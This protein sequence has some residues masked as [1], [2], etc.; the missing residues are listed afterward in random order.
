[1]TNAGNLTQNPGILLAHV[2]SDI[3]D[4]SACFSERDGCGLVDMLMNRAI[5]R[6]VCP[7]TV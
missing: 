7:V 6:S 4:G 5:V 1:M 3:L 2:D